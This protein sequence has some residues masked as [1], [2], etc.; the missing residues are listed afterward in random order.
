M[1]PE[2]NNVIQVS[3]MFTDLKHVKTKKSC[4]EIKFHE[5]LDTCEKNENVILTCFIH[6]I[7]IFRIYFTGFPMFEN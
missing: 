4:L 5:N 6:M 3:H 1:I 7:R 2:H